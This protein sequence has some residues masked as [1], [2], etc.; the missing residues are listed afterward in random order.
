M[1]RSANNQFGKSCDGRAHVSRECKGAGSQR[2]ASCLR[3]S[4][5][6]VSTVN[7]TV[8]SAQKASHRLGRLVLDFLFP[9]QCLACRAPVAESHNLCALCWG[10]ITFLSDPM[11]TV[12]GF[13]FEY[14]TGPDTVCAGCRERQPVFDGA[15]A[16]MRYDN[17][18]RDPVLALKRA[19]RL[20][21][22]PLFARWMAM[23]GRDLL[24]RSDLIIP[25][26]LHRSRLWHRRF[27]QSALIAH[28]L[29]KIARKPVD[30]F[31]LERAR[32][33]PSQGE[34][35]SAHARQRNVQGAFCIS[36]SERVRG[37]AILLIDDVYTTG[38]TV[39]ACARALKRAGAIRI[40]V[41]A[42]ARVVRR[43]P[44]PI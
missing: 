26:P 19:D 18:S 27:N 8:F 37:K 2:T 13:P 44:N 42:L 28:A 23:A 3:A 35:P 6:C 32:P 24:A 10:K 7:A 12:C 11:C 5:V 43:L 4:R 29:G 36:R 17:A 38:A 39:E 31:A 20:D 16:L 1:S 33:T 41:L 9:P 22:V 15:R 34:M 25:V 21:L 30:C 14:E 40:F